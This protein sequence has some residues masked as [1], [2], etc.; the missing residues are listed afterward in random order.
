MP[1]KK[2]SKALQARFLK[3][4]QLTKDSFDKLAELQYDENLKNVTNLQNIISRQFVTITELSETISL[5]HGTINSLNEQIN[6]NKQKLLSL[7]VTKSKTTKHVRKVRDNINYNEGKARDLSL[8]FNNPVVTNVLGNCRKRQLQKPSG[9]PGL[10]ERTKVRRAD[11]TMKVCSVIHGGGVSGDIESVIK[12]M[13]HTLSLKCPVALLAPRMLEM[14]PAIT[15]VI[16]ES[17]L[18]RECLDFFKSDANLLRSLN[19]YYCSN[20]L[21]KNKYIAV[22]KANEKRNIPNVVPYI[23]LAKKIREINIGELIPI[24]GTLDSNLLDEERGV[25]FYRNL[26]SYLPRLA[27]FYIHVN[28]KRHDK[29]MEFH[30]G[31]LEASSFLFLFSIGG[32]E[33]PASGTTFLV[34][35]LNAGKRICSSFDNFLIFGGTVKEN[36]IIVKR[37][38]NRL[39]ADIKYLE[40]RYFKLNINGKDFQVEF[41]LELLPND[42]KML[43][44]LA[45]ELTN[46]AYYFSTFANVHKDN[47]NVLDKCYNTGKSTDWMPFTYQKR[48]NDARLVEQKKAELLKKNNSATTFRRNTTTYI[49]SLKSRQEFVPLVDKYVDKAMAEPL[50]LKNNVCKEVFMKVWD[51]VIS[52]AQ[53]NTTIKQFKFIPHDNLLY[54]FIQFVRKEMKSN[55]LSK[56]LKEYWDSCRETRSDFSFRFRGE[57]SRNYLTGFPS[58][59]SMLFDK[60]LIDKWRNM[61]M[62]I[63]ILSTY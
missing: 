53:V 55:K 31:K 26:Q 16:S 17:V 32:D 14:K 48:L 63:F 49:K 1:G 58:L 39:V 9:L 34:S 24:E 60:I 3:I 27:E 33:A 12:G 13:L 8:N 35:F 56:K 51:V 54:E 22:R 52:V 19:I 2:G 5:Q 11:D 28:H 43:A 10:S 30:C 50:H 37:Y 46:S 23:K 29:L 7:N 38:V 40:S 62:V 15:K 25:G 45:G 36:G 18:S 47:A 44:F 21:G 61:L 57:E 41:K 20:V 4:G 42:M 59:I 6:E